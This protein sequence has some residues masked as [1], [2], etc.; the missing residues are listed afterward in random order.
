[1]IN[2]FFKAKLGGFGHA[3]S[4]TKEKLAND[5]EYLYLR[6]RFSFIYKFFLIFHV[7]IRTLGKTLSDLFEHNFGKEITSKSSASYDFI[8]NTRSYINRFKTQHLK[9]KEN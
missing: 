4:L 7:I 6:N 1:M 9:K 2:F 5:L 8:Q 3:T